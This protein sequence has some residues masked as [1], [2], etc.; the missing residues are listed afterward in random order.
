[1][2]FLN[3]ISNKIVVDTI[4]IPEERE[5]GES[6]GGERERDWKRMERAHQALASET[7]TLRRKTHID[8][9]DRFLVEKC[10]YFIFDIVVV[11][12][13]QHQHSIQ[14]NNNNTAHILLFAWS[15]ST[16]PIKS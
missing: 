15:I 14:E 10:Y 9:C 7:K 16:F 4:K 5:G 13:S 11:V 3:D 8:K 12:R 2:P 6:E 1:M